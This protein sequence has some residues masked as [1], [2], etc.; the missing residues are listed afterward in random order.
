VCNTLVI[1]K[2]TKH[3]TLRNELTNRSVRKKQLDSIKTRPTPKSVDQKSAT[4]ENTNISDEITIEDSSAERFTLKKKRLKPHYWTKDQIMRR[5]NNKKKIKS[6][7]KFNDNS[8]TRFV[9]VCS[10]EFAKFSSMARLLLSY[11]IS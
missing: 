7:S 5:Q 3:K 6:I 4:K 2:A 9:F 11:H 1:F 10:F 8:F